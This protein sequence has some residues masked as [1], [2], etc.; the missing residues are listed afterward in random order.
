MSTGLG[1]NMSQMLTTMLEVLV[2]RRNA[3]HE[4]GDS[5]TVSEI[6]RY[7]NILGGAVTELGALT[8][9]EHNHIV[10]RGTDLPP[11][12]GIAA[13]V[14]TARLTILRHLEGRGDADLPTAAALLQRAIDN[15]EQPTP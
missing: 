9:E 13:D 7:M 5:E 2:D 12:R 11:D 10:A 15:L 6:A 1:E 4:R 14:I 8:V 3:A